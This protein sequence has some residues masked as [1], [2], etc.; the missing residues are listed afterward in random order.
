MNYGLIKKY[1][2]NRIFKI[3][4]L[5]KAGAKKAPACQN[6]IVSKL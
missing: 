1:R 6:D 3:R 2:T 5:I 4:E